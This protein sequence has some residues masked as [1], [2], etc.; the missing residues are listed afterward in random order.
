MFVELNGA[1]QRRTEGF[2]QSI[3]SVVEPKLKMENGGPSWWK[4]DGD[5]FAFLLS[6]PSTATQP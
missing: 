2:N 5:S 4:M 1:E 6:D 3:G